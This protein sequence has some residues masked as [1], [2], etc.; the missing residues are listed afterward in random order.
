MA[1]PHARGLEFRSGLPI[2]VELRLYRLLS[3]GRV[4]DRRLQHHRA[5]CRTGVLQFY[6]SPRAR[7]V[8]RLAAHRDL[9]IPPTTA[10][11]QLRLRRSARVA[12]RGRI[13]VRPT[14]AERDPERRVRCEPALHTAAVPAQRQE[15]HSLRRILRD[16]RAGERHQSCRRGV[17]VQLRAARCVNRHRQTRSTRQI[18]ARGHGL[19]RRTGIMIHGQVAARVEPD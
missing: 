13:G 8:G 1:R 17:L 6:R 12:A 14:A 3:S 2:E 16:D 19:A 7:L 15:L 4:G 18:P 9:V 5:Q 11:G 10:P